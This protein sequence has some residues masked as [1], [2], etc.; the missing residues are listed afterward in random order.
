MFGWIKKNLFGKQA[1]VDPY[2]QCTIEFIEECKR[3]NCVP[4]SYDPQARSFQFTDGRNVNLHNL[5]AAWLPLDQQ[6]RAEAVARFVRSIDESPK[7]ADISPEALPDQLMPGIRPRALIGNALLQHW[8]DGAPADATTEIAWLPFAA[9][10]A[11]CV[12]RD[13]PLTMAPMARDNLAFAGLPIED[14]MSKAMSNFRARM[15][16]VVFEP[17]GNGVFGCNN[18]QDHQSALLLLEPGKDYALPP[19]EGAPVALVPG[20]NVFY[21]TGSA[22]LPG[23]ITLLEMSETAGQ[24]PNFCSSMILQWAGDRWS[25][26]RFEPGTANADRQ[27]LIALRQ[28]TADYASQKQMLDQYYLN[29]GL[30]IAVSELLAF[31]KQD[32]AASVISIT[33]LA[34]GTSGTL[35]P[36]A[37]RLSFVRQTIDPKTGVAQNGSEDVADVTWSEAMDMVGH[38]FEPVDHLYP[39]RFRALGFPEADAWTKLK[40]LT[41]RV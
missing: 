14:A 9:D 23:L 30:D 11:A 7:H 27:R 31:Q 39:P 18:F 15:P 32:R 6:G 5:F 41:R 28:A 20:R 22:N 2:D 17:V 1:E 8:I 12:V 3:Q 33:V 26:F 29:Q 35:L 37:E 16:A 4:A 19:I 36:Q 40:A 38:L 10:L 34:S 13:M 24:T 25:E 21:L